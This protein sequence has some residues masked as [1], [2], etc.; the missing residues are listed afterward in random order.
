MVPIASSR[1]ALAVLATA[2]AGALVFW[3][4]DAL[5]FQDLPA[6]AGLI[7]LRHRLP[8]SPFEQRFYVLSPHLGPYSLFR[9]SGDILRGLVGPVGA[10]RALM[11]VAVLAI[12]ASLG[13]SRHRLRGDGGVAAAGF[14]LS[15]AFGF[16]TAMGFASYLLGMAALVVALT[17]WLEVVDAADRRDPSVLRRELTASLSAVVVVFVHG[18][19]FATFIALAVAIAA[20][21]GD[22]WRRLPRTRALAPGVALACWMLWQ[23]HLEHRAQPP[24]A[25]GAAQRAHFAPWI[26]KLSLLGTPT[27]L[28]RWGIDLL[29]GLFLWSVVGAALV[30]TIRGRG[31]GA[32][33]GRS[34]DAHT[35]GAL[36]ALVVLGAAFVA[37]P[38]SI[39]WFGFVDGRLVPLLLMLGV[40]AVDRRAL[41]PRLGVAFDHGAPVAAAAMVSIAWVASLRFQAEARGWK[42]V[43]AAIPDNSLLLNLPVDPN[44][45]VLTGH[46]FVHY[47]KLAMASRP[48]VVS[49]VWFH[50]GTALYPA[51]DHPALLLPPTYSESNLGLVDW[52]SY[53]LTDWDYV[54]VRVRPDAPAPRVPGALELARHE[55]GWWLYRTGRARV[56]TSV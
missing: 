4:F 16:M 19:A 29:V 26:D 15:C 50:Q 47:D 10:V 38:H 40:L 51:P 32:P 2:A 39:G 36:V 25:L 14:G 18:F 24:G 43:L 3:A 42:D 8:V 48:T 28:T 5:P 35:R 17:F 54:L 44:S 52:P 7:A 6:H 23:E 1:A 33:G 27:L 46:P 9:A 20:G 45:D 12:P 30:A 56:L 37:L 55:G 31:A 11:T 34:A 13:W 21:T 53:R 22:R 49:D 41:G